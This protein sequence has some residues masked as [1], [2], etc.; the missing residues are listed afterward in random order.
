MKNILLRMLGVWAVIV[1]GTVVLSGCGK[2]EETRAIGAAERAGRAADKVAQDTVDDADRAAAATKEAS[3]KAVQ[4]A[5]ERLKKAGEAIE[6]I[7][8]DLQK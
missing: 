4:K 8:A 5:D 6:D 1:I 7:G 2:K 3:D